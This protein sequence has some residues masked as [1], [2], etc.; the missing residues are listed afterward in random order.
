[1][2]EGTKPPNS[3]LKVLQFGFYGSKFK[4]TAAQCNDVMKSVSRADP[5]KLS[6]AE[7]LHED[8]GQNPDGA[9]QKFK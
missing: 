2:R 6:R 8:E 4:T 5:I 1:V 9:E 7:S 3:D